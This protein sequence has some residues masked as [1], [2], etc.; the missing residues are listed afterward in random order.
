MV[1]ERG[2]TPTS[3]SEEVPRLVRPNRL[4][5]AG[6]RRV[7]AAGDQ[8][9]VGQSQVLRVGATD[10][11][12]DLRAQVPIRDSLAM[13]SARRETLVVSGLDSRRRVRL[14]ASL[15]AGRR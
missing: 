2:Q 14:G 5:V 11:V 4:V 6:T 7:S 12:P 8:E 9:S 13:R 3:W 15:R 10:P 1:P